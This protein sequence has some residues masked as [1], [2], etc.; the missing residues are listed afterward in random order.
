MKRALKDGSSYARPP[1]PP[2][3]TIDPASGGTPGPSQPRRF[4]AIPGGFSW[5]ALAAGWG[6]GWVVACKPARCRGS[7]GRSVDCLAPSV[8]FPAAFRPRVARQSM[9]A[10]DAIAAMLGPFAGVLELFLLVAIGW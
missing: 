3:S 1:E 7:R 10:G 2:T 9:N 8:A 4:L 5:S 6:G